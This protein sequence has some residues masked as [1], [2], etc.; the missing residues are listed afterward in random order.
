MDT[1]INQFS[2]LL[3]SPPGNIT[4]YLVVGFSVAWTLQ[5]A[6]GRYSLRHSMH[7]RR[8]VWGMATMLVMRLAL[9]VAILI[10]ETT[11]PF[12]DFLPPADRAI[13]VLSL[14]IIAWLW[15]FPE[16][17]RFAD[18]SGFFLCVFVLVF[19]GAS[20]AG[21]S[22][23]APAVFFNAT[24]LGPLWE[25]LALAVSGGGILLLFSRKSQNWGVGVWALVIQFTGSA[26]S[27]AFPELQSNYAAFS[28][29]GQMIAY[30]LLFTLSQYRH[31][32][33]IEEELLP[34]TAYSG[35]AD[36]PT[37]LPH[38]VL[39]SLIDD[40]LDYTKSVAGQRYS[41]LARL[42]GHLLPH[43]TVLV[44]IPA[45]KENHYSIAGAAG[46]DLPKI[47]E[48][49]AVKS[50]PLIG[51]A[52]QRGR[53]LSLPA[54][55]SSIDLSTLK[56]II[57]S[58]HDF[59]ILACPLQ[60][61]SQKT[62]GAVLL[63]RDKPRW[64]GAE[65]RLINDLA[66]SFSRLL[67]LPSGTSPFE[68]EIIQSL[69]TQEEQIFPQDKKLSKEDLRATLSQIWVQN[70]QMRNTLALF[71]KHGPQ[72]KE[73]LFPPIDA[74][75]ELSKNVDISTLSREEAIAALGNALA[76]YRLDHE[77]ILQLVI[78]GKSNLLRPERKN[79]LQNIL[80]KL[81]AQNKGLISDLKHTQNQL[82]RIDDALGP[83][84]VQ[85][86]SQL[87]AR[88]HS[89][90]SM[91]E[92]QSALAVAQAQNEERAKEI[93][94]LQQALKELQS[95][96]R[97]HFGQSEQK[98]METRERFFQVSSQQVS[99]IAAAVQQ[100][101]YPLSTIVDYSD[102]VLDESV[103]SLGALQ[104]K[105][106][107]RIK[108][109]VKQLEEQINQLVQTSVLD[110]SKISLSADIFDLNIIVESALAAVATSVKDKNIHLKQNL[111][112][113][114]PFV[115]IDKDATEQILLILLRNAIQATPPDG[116]V[117]LNIRLDEDK[118][119]QYALIQ[120]IDTGE[121]IPAEDLPQVFS[122]V[123]RMSRLPIPG[124]GDTDIGL[125]VAKT[126]VDALKG[127]IWVDSEVGKGATFSALLPLP[128]SM[129]LGENQ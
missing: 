56:N 57:Q 106:L 78:E 82:K 114:L 91:V 15:A 87:T 119:Q 6:I 85:N 81:Q 115:H 90:M 66:S 72:A 53:P 34:S 100:L 128:F 113:D 127:R 75:E 96:F 88:P 94:R 12:L 103:G 32:N 36:T 73:N 21:W 102:L 129:I 47:K 40:F 110:S 27:L 67:L 23:H 98:V 125:S 58:E 13:N 8:L 22:G 117:E 16:K 14:I 83:A 28:R 76:Q 63:L 61:G 49:L 80:I 2:S 11:N 105:F 9:F 84:A 107:E 42:V 123:Y 71:L 7:S 19:F 64:S 68:D 10:A 79:E 24:L 108:D 101:H 48:P 29:L 97:I 37:G 4:Y 120:V 44:L 77:T 109:A 65:Q 121:G 25:A 39:A 20:L 69:S 46:S 99:E 104:R 3:T 126:L 35:S 62:I 124:I 26:L 111:S 122:P 51:N 93:T 95:T 112:S 86:L 118:S 5:S 89:N 17:S 41:A 30:P 92:L 70:R 38:S 33:L 74:L 52:L 45:D 31:V 116:K 54:D 50:I 60:D 55:N 1:L 18:G 43:R 59:H